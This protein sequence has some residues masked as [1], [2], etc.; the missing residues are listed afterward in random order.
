MLRTPT[1]RLHPRLFSRILR[2]DAPVRWTGVLLLGMASSAVGAA[3]TAA[4]AAHDVGD[5]QAV[6]QMAPAARL[7]ARLD[8]RTSMSST[9]GLKMRLRPQDA[10]LSAYHPPASISAQARPAALPASLDRS[11]AQAERAPPPQ[12]AA[13][14]SEGHSYKPLAMLA[15]A[16]AVMVSIA[17]RRSGK[18]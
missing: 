8:A 18:R 4:D 10:V 16:L 5:D 13:E 15:A 7:D 6:V 14:T 9:E 11:T 12:P 1:Y 2:F 17:L 3:C